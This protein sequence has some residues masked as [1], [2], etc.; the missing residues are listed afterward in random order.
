MKQSIDLESSISGIPCG[1]HVES[2]TVVPP[3]RG[4]PYACDSA[5]DYYGYAE[6]EFT[7]LDRKGYPAPWL[8]NKLTPAET[9]RIEDEILTQRENLL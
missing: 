9:R 3:F 8:A 6:I 5:D 2:C 4:S 7:V 1:I